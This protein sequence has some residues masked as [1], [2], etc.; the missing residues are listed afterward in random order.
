M[1]LLGDAGTMAFPQICHFKPIFN[2]PWHAQKNIWT[3]L[4]FL[5]FGDLG[6]ALAQCQNIVSSCTGEINA[7]TQFITGTVHLAVSNSCFYVGSGDSLSLDG[8]NNQVLVAAGG[9]VNFNGVSNRALAQAGATVGFCG[10]GYGNWVY[11]EPGVNLVCATQ[12]NMQDCDEI[13]FINTVGINAL[14]WEER[15]PAYDAARQVVLVQAGP[16]SA[17]YVLH[18]AM[19]RTAW[20]GRLNGDA[21]VDMARLPSGTYLLQ[22]TDQP[23]GQSWRFAR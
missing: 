21:L 11:R 16:G 10:S 2:S 9:K 22:R 17:G 20:S 3:A 12:N 18:D 5:A 8:L 4:L 19:G 13:I 14:A 6:V 7:D 1:A 23:G 15:L